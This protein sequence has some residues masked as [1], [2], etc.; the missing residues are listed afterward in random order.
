MIQQIDSQQLARFPQ[1]LGYGYILAAWFRVAGRVIV[2]HDD[3]CGHELDS[4]GKSFSRVNQICAQCAPADFTP[5][6][7]A[8]SDIEEQGHE[9]FLRA[10]ADALLEEG[11]RIFRASYFGA[12]FGPA[13]FDEFDVIE[14]V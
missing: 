6:Q 5:A 2:R 1:T 3:A 4:S 8:I 7:K 9:V 11:D 14:F 13:F 12:V 10:G